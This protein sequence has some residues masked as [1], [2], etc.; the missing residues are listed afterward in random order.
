MPAA[1]PPHDGDSADLRSGDA[2]AIARERTRHVRSGAAVTGVLQN[3]VHEPGAP[4]TAAAGRGAAEI[5]TGLSHD[6][7]CPET[8]RRG[9][10]FDRTR[11]KSGIGAGKSAPPHLRHS[12]IPPRAAH[13]VPMMAM[14]VVAGSVMGPL[15][16][17]G[18]P[19]Y[20][21]VRPC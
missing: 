20:A 19:P 5:T 12:G 18:V 1:P 11:R 21:V 15:T 10:A 14:G 6:V 8:A 2:V 4:K 13:C 9:R 17:L 3:H 7:R 16:H